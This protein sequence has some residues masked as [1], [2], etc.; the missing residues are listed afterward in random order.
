MGGV[1]TAKRCGTRACGQAGRREEAHKPCNPKAQLSSSRRQQERRAAAALVDPAVWK[2]LFCQSR[3]TAL[4]VQINQMK[5]DRLG[6]STEPSQILPFQEPAPLLHFPSTPT[7]KGTQWAGPAAM[8]VHHLSRSAQRYQSK[9]VSHTNLLMSFCQLTVWLS[10]LTPNCESTRH[11]QQSSWPQQ[12]MDIHLSACEG[13]V[14]S[15]WQT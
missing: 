2:L 14:I 11:E 13:A 9:P 7:G 12:M 3:I 1:S 15:S 6:N 8:W 10:D 4:T 5:T